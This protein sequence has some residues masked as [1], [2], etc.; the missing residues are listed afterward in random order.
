MAAILCRPQSDKQAMVDNIGLIIYDI[1]FVSIPDISN[2]SYQEPITL[3]AFHH[4][5]N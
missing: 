2:N 4:K 5:S 3:M 1:F